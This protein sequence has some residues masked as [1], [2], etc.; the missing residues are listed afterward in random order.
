[1]REA[2]LVF[3]G[4]DHSYA[5]RGKFIGTNAATKHYQPK[6]GAAFDVLLPETQCYEL[7]TLKG[8]YLTLRSYDLKTGEMFDEVVLPHPVW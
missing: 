8:N 7:I 5:R 6:K 2:D 4:H 3:S 1:M